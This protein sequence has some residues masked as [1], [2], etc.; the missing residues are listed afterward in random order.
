[1]TTT[2][3]T[4]TTGT[5]TIRPATKPHGIER[6]HDV[7]IMDSD[8]EII[9]ECFE[10]VGRTSEGRFIERPAYANAAHIVHCVNTYPAL[11]AALKECITEEG[12]YCLNHDSKALLRGRLASITLLAKQAIA[13]AEGSTL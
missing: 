10:K 9:A 8:G 3:T 1:M 5:W 11:L 2:Q 12:A 4:H 7:A 6:S 13:L